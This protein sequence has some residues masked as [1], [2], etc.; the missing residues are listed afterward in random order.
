MAN[1]GRL[2]IYHN[3]IKWYKQNRTYQNNKKKILPTGWW[4]VR[5]DKSATR[6]QKKQ[7][8]FGQRYGERKKEPNGNAEWIDN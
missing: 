2:K 6:K 4:R 5:K 3:R 7:N 8:N 1:E